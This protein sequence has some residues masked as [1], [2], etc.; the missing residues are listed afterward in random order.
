MNVKEQISKQVEAHQAKLAMEADLAGVTE[1]LEGKS[2]KEVLRFI[3]DARHEILSSPPETVLELHQCIKAIYGV[4]VPYTSTHPDFH[5]PLEAMAA[6]YFGTHE[7]IVWLAARGGMKTL[8]SSIIANLL[9]QFNP[10]FES[11]HAGGTQTQAKVAAKYLKNFY[12]IPPMKEYFLQKPGVFQAEWR[13][14]STWNIVTG[15]FGG[16]SGQHPRLLTLDEI[17]V[18]DRE[19]LMQTFEVPTSADGYRRRWAAFSTRQRSFGAMNWLI[20][21]AP[22]RG[23]HLY[24]WTLFE[25]MR[26]CVTCKAI[27]ENPHGDDDCR[28]KSCIL[29]E[30]CKGTRARKSTGWLTLKQAQEKCVRLGGP[31]GREFLTQGVC[32]RPSSHGLVLHNFEK[33]PRP[34]GNY[35]QW[36]YVK[37]LPWFALHDP[38]EG[39][40]SVIYFIQMDG[41]R[42]FV[43]D[44]LVDSQCANVMQAKKAFYEHCKKMGY[45]DPTVIVVDPHKPDAVADWKEGTPHGE[46]I[47]HSYKADMPDISEDTGVSDKLVTTLEF[48]RKYIFDGVS[49]RLFVNKDYCPSLDWAIGEYHYP[50]SRATNEIQSDT[51]SKE[52]S[53][54]IDPLRYWVMYLLTKFKHGRLRFLFL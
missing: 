37:E 35:T 45:T 16:V 47:M 42:T 43:F 1:H 24:Q 3:V 36:T 4:S 41:D 49:R 51:P 11:I 5:A 48:L 15:S 17:E 52:Y 8:G 40:K 21:E 25:M 19:A 31:Q 46:G 22:K 7:D 9:N 39:K 53:D 23:M 6:M 28:A 34:E 18:W 20:D 54:E 44:E 38:A 14:G 33:K 10:S 27:D 50:V 13:N 26:P 30:H 29:W 2:P 12:R 32:Q